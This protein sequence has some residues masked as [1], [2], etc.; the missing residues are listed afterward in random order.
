MKK[1]LLLILPLLAFVSCTKD[2]DHQPV[3]PRAV[4][5]LAAA[6]MNEMIWW[7]DSV[8]RPEVIYS[9]ASECSP[10]VLTLSYDGDG[11]LTTICEIHYDEMSDAYEENLD[12]LR[13]VYRNFNE[14]EKFDFVVNNVFQYRADG[15]LEAIGK[16]G[17]V[18][19]EEIVERVAAAAPGHHLQAVLRPVMSY[20][21]SDI[22][23]GQMVLCVEEVAD[24][25]GKN[26]N[27][28][29][30]WILAGTIDDYDWDDY[31]NGKIEEYSV[32]EEHDHY[33]KTIY[34]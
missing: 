10:Q 27:P 18:D 3:G 34:F 22:R 28:D 13:E 16:G 17:G 2:A 30:R 26:D 33:P 4:R 9:R 24:R 32:F 7:E 14:E 21:C 20:W 25:T 23:G 6:P 8:G 12:S 31:F 1:I 5:I 15:A 11:R 19:N 29:K